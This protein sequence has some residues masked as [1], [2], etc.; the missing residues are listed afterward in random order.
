MKKIILSLLLAVVSTGAFAQFE[1]GTKYVGANLQ[2]TGLGMGYSK[3]TDFFIGLQ[4]NAGYFIADSWML[5]GEFGWNHQNGN[6][7]V[8]LG[9]GARYYMKQNGLYFAGLL[10]YKHIPSN[11]NNVY[12]SPEVGYC[13]YLNDH[14]SIEPA[15]YVDMCLNHFKDFTQVGL[16]IGFGYY[17]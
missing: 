10:K 3:S 14:I 17:F 11:I 2:G 5:L 12:L 7:S 1:K 9:A 16:K 6:S 8:G 13:F 4:A 15:V